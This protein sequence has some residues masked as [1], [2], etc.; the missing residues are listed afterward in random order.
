[1]ETIQVVVTAFAF[2]AISMAIFGIARLVSWMGDHSPD[3]TALIRK[4]RSYLLADDTRLLWVLA[5]I[6]LVTLVAAAL[7]WATAHRFWLPERVLR[8]SAPIV[9]DAP[10]WH[11]VFYE[12]VPDG[13]AV[14]VSCELQDGHYIGGQLSWYSTETDE[15]ADREIVL[16]PP[17]FRVRPDADDDDGIPPQVQRLV[18]SARHI[19]TLQVIY[20][21]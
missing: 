2:T 15:T 6:A 9:V 3:P 18:I 16:A 17:L 1:M 8:W 4:P 12:E 11:R 20:V 10:A 21:S 7:A 5:W 14:Y 13:A 19:R